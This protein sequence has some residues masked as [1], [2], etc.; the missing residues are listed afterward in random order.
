MSDEVPRAGRHDC[1]RTRD[2]QAVGARGDPS[3]AAEVA[4]SS[5]T[6]RPDARAATD[7]RPIARC[8]GRSAMS[9]CWRIS[10]SRCSDPDEKERAWQRYHAIR[11][12]AEAG[13]CR[14]RQICT[15]FGETP[16]WTTCGM[17]DVCAAVPEWMEKSAAA[18]TRALR[19]RKKKGAAW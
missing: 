5:I 2:Q 8:S 12:F 6:R 10:S 13:E 9:A 18:G 19:R 3:V 15:H 17:C 7:C 1:L 16:K 11:R 14:H 4:S